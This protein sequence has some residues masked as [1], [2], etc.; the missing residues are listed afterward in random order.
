MALGTC[1]CRNC[2]TLPLFLMM[3]SAQSLTSHL[4]A[5]RSQSLACTEPLVPWLLVSLSIPL[6][7]KAAPAQC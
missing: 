3:Q 5:T 6:P 1:C 7:T 2:G 4:D